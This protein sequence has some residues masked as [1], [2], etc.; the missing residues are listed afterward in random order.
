[1]CD[2]FACAPSKQGHHGAG[3]LGKVPG[4]ENDA[5]VFRVVVRVAVSGTEALGEEAGV[6][7]KGAWEKTALSEDLGN[8]SCRASVAT[9][10][11]RDLR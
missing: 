6:D 10:D 3:V 9:Q 7:V 8:V 1:M 2:F 5:R 4:V 11:A